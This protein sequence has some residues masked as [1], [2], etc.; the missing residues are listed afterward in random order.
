MT[1]AA[2]T[3]AIPAIAP[4]IEELRQESATTRRVLDRV[5]A[6][7]LEWKPCE[8]S[9]TAGQIALHVAMLPGI[10][11]RILGPDTFAPPAG[12]FVFPS[13]KS[14]DEIL[15]TFDTSIK[16]AQEFLAGLSDEQARGLWTT[17]SEGRTIMQLPRAKAVRTL[18]LNHSIHHRGQLSI[19]LREMGVPVPSIYG[20]SGD[21]N[22]FT[23]K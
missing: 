19:Y 13:P 12:A 22:P 11:A 8:T 14:K 16:A 2:A 20:P 5:P 15:S 23:P 21:E 1:Q 7:K 18:M 6:D 17:L 3:A 9:L 4:M 10:F